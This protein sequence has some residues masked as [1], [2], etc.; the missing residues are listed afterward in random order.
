MEPHPEAGSCSFKVQ[1]AACF[2]L[3]A[4]GSERF[5]GMS[6][7]QRGLMPVAGLITEGQAKLYGTTYFGGG[8]GCYKS[9]GGARFFRVHPMGER[10][11]STLSRRPAVDASMRGFAGGKERH[12]LERT[13]GGADKLG[14]I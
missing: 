9:A 2:Q 13:M 4:G 1:T 8:S 12:F 10:R 3:S 11:L 14:I 7:R 5:V 6:G